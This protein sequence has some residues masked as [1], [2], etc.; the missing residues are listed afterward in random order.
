MI[1]A[2]SGSAYLL[3]TPVGCTKADQVLQGSAVGKEKRAVPGD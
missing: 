2:K 1:A 3:Q